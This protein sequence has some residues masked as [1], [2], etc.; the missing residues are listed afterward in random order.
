[1]LTGRSSSDR[2]T[3][4][5]TACVE[6]CAAFKAGW[7]LATE[8]MSISL[9]VGFQMSLGRANAA[10]GDNPLVSKSRTASLPKVVKDMAGPP[11]LAP[12]YG[13]SRGVEV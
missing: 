6:G 7:L 12:R 13:D 10:G 11:S 1:V 4:S 8:A 2:S 5:S 9:I 3:S